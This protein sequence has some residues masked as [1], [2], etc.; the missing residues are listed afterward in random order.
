MDWLLLN[1]IEVILLGSAMALY[2]LPSA[3][4]M[5]KLATATMSVS[6]SLALALLLFTDAAMAHTTWKLIVIALLW[7][8]SFA[9]I[10]QLQMYALGHFDTG[11]LFASTSVASMVLTIFVGLLFFGDH[12][13]L[14]Q[15]A[16]ILLAVIVVSV[17]MFHQKKA[18]KLA[19]I[20]WVLGA[21]ITFVSVFNKVLQ[22]FAVLENVEAFQ[23]WQYLFAVLTSLVALLW[24]H[25]GKVREQFTRSATIVGASIGS[26]SFFGGYLMLK[27]LE[28][29]P[30]TLVMS[31]HS[32]YIIITAIIGMLLFKE[33]ISARKAGLFALAVAAVILMRVG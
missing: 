6:V 7:G 3:K 29:G 28:T 12:I 1:I 33:R 22:K 27:A 24:V 19:T 15:G 8:I 30:F 20:A 21:M 10:M 25:R 5:S 13:S 2:K 11:V 9:A 23:I 4:G 17:L 16:G 31:I 18:A 26:L 14:L 32:L